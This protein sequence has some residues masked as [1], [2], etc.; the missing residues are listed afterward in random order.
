MYDIVIVG[1]GVAGLYAAYLAAKHGLKTLVIERLPEDRIGEKVCGDAVGKHHVDWAGL[2]LR[3]GVEIVH[4]YVGAR[5]VSPDQQHHI[6]VPGEGYAVDRK[7]FGQRLL[8]LAVNAGA[9]VWAGHRFVKPV[10]EGSWLR[11]VVVRD[12]GGGTKEVRGRIHVDA[13]G[14]PAVVRR[15]LPSTW[16]VSEPVPPSDYCL[17]YREIWVADIDLGEE[18]QNLV[19]IYLDEQ[20]AP[21]GYWWLFPKGGGVYNVGLGV[22]WR[23]GAPNPRKQFEEF[24]RRRFMGRIET[25]VHSGG[26]LVPT[27]R[28]IP[29]MV[30]N[31]LMVVGDAA[32][33]ANPV[34]GGGI[35]PALRGARLAIDVAVKAIEEGDTSMRGL[36]RYQRLYHEAYGAKQA[37]LDVA[38]MFLQRLS[39]EDL[40]LIFRSGIIDSAGIYDLGTHGVLSSRT[41]SMLGSALRLAVSRPTM[42]RHL[43]KLKSFMERAKQ[44]YLEF[45]ESPEGYEEW[46]RRE[47]EFFEEYR[48]WLDSVAPR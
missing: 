31:G 9:E 2:D 45:P 21:G 20:V 30:W 23:P 33:L 40:N 26:G 10:V 16:W 7:R 25:V 35:G 22:Q 28:P 14:V 8:E 29:C 6:D 11:G 12:E 41:L 43:A 47:R 34:H 4:R 13:T 44:L 24:I 1:G 38:R 36:W 18:G 48:R 27:R 42:L 32:C 19:W 37:A 3:P 46:R 15:S 5:V 17:T 39:N